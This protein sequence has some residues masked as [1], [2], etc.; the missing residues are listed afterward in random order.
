MVV[1]LQLRVMQIEFW[2]ECLRITGRT[3]RDVRDLV[4]ATANNMTG[5]VP[6]NQTHDPLRL[7]ADSDSL[8]MH[9]EVC[10]AVVAINYRHNF[11]GSRLD[12]E[13][14]FGLHAFQVVEYRRWVDTFSHSFTHPCASSL[15]AAVVCTG[16]RGE[17]PSS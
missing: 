7:S 10:L 14:V 5:M 4:N 9:V 6:A 17:S 1:C 13:A 12:W 15:C 11:T 16:S 8:S 2:R 3:F